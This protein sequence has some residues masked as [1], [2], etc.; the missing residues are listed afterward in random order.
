[1]VIESAIC[2]GI[3][4]RKRHKYDIAWGLIFMFLVCLAHAFFIFFIVKKV[5][6]VPPVY[7]RVCQLASLR[8]KSSTET[9]PSSGL[10]AARGEDRWRQRFLDQSFIF[11][12][13][14]VRGTHT[15]MIAMNI[16]D[17]LSGHAHRWSAVTRACVRR[18]KSTLPC[19]MRSKPRRDSTT[20]LRSRRRNGSAKR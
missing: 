12:N 2:A 6:P 18:T 7:G 9:I 14:R 8:A 4:H 19:V 17:C 5:R 13:G 16:S 10:L 1:M 3:A 20:S 15:P 11:L